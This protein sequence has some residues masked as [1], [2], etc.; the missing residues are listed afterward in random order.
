MEESIVISKKLINQREKISSEKR[1]EQSTFIT[2]NL[3]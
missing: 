1:K 3:A 2:K